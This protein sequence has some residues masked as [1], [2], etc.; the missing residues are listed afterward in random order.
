MILGEIVKYNNFELRFPLLS[1]NVII[2]GMY[3]GILIA[4]LLGIY[5]KKYEGEAVR[6]LLERGINTAEDAL[7]LSELGLKPSALR[8]HALRSGVVRKY[9]RAAGAE[10]EETKETEAPA[11][12][13]ASTENAMDAENAEGTKDA[14]NVTGAEAVKGA[15]NTVDAA[16]K[17]P[18]EDAPL[19]A[20][21]LPEDL[22][23]AR[24]YIPTALA[25]KAYLRYEEKGTGIGVF[26][27]AAVA[28][29]VLAVLLTVFVPEL[30]QMLD[31]LISYVK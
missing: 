4:C 2:W 14:E 12:D 30:T 8:L 3:G 19:V 13:A 7:T 31:N 26:F 9:I 28:F 10:A 1:L 23:N 11:E 17:V 21:A 5:C 18:A 22:K 20:V 15:E 6:R 16:D 25:D 27:A 29:L 24:L